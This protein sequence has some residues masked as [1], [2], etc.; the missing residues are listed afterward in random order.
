MQLCSCFRQEGRWSLLYTIVWPEVRVHSGPSDSAP[1]CHFPIQFIN[2][3]KITELS[4]GYL[5]FT[6]ALEKLWNYPW[7]ASQSS[8]IGALEYRIT[9]RVWSLKWCFSRCSGQTVF[10]GPSRCWLKTQIHGSCTRPN[11]A[12]SLRMA[13]WVILTYCN[14]SSCPTSEG[15]VREREQLIK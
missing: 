7:V 14:L 11:E 5:S 15:K 1:F 3:T 13:L 2:S 6:W 10:T 9:S 4:T 12:K 8:N